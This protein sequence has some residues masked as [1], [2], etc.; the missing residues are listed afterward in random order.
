M[1]LNS[2]GE[3]NRC[4]IP[5][6]VLVE[7]DDEQKGRIRKDQKEIEALQRLLDNDDMSWE[8]RKRRELELAEVKRKKLE[9]EDE[10]KTNRKRRRIMKYNQI[11]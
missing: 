2:K 8:E 7:E 9:D 6:L 11:W 5:R 4:H 3:F 10:P 1:I